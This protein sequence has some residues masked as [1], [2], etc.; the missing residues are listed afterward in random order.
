MNIKLSNKIPTKCDF[1]LV[2]L[3]E[4]EKLH[5]IGPAELTDILKKRESKKDFKAKEGESITLY[6]D[7]ETLPA[8]ICLFGLGK[9][10]KINDEKVRNNAAEM[11]KKAK[12]AKSKQPALFIPTE[13]A[14]FAQPL[15]EGLTLANY[16]LGKYQTGKAKE[17]NEAHSLSTVEIICSSKA[18]NLSSAL[19]RG[20]LIAEAVNE[21]RDLVNGPNNLIN[22]DTLPGIA[23]KIAQAGGS[24]ITVYSKKQLENMKMGALLGVGQGSARDPKMLVLEYNPK[25]A[26]VKE[27]IMLVG[28]GVTFDSGGYNL[29]PT[30]AITNM[31][32][33]MAGA[34]VVLGVFRLLKKLNIKHRVIGITPLTDNMIGGKA[35]AVNDIV[36]AY[37]GKTIEITNTDAEG[38]LILADAIAYGVK[39]YNPKYLVDLATLTGA[40]M[41]A[42]GDRYAG[43]FGNN[44]Q[45]VEA[46]MKSGIKT[47]ELLWELPLHKKHS[48]EMKS[49]IADLQNS[50]SSGLAGASKGAAFVKEFIGKTDWAHIDIAGV[51]FVNDPKPYDFPAATGFGVRLLADFLEGLE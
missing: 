51:T 24:K 46:L 40:C 17:K 7:V 30:S 29:K 28:K 4:D 50:S 49:K 13:M 6:P 25:G 36:T 48:E 44:K 22:P 16:T 31:K 14:H 42:L 45:L 20:A 11:A 12:K 43:L 9:S 37:N 47:D 15:A 32:E 34:A 38:R 23:R 3:F 21:T 41:V 18:K 33:D 35:Q 5:A 8:K 27:P 39:K 26:K 2:G 1:L 10:G 19:K